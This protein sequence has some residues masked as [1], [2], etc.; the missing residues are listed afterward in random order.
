MS[1]NLSCAYEVF[2][3]SFPG[4]T[5]DEQIDARINDWCA[6]GYSGH[7]YYGQTKEQ[8][9]HFRAQFNNA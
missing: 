9:E 2:N 1:D 4:M 3:P 7:C 6:E 8:A 5:L